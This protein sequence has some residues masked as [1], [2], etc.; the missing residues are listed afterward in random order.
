[1]QPRSANLLRAGVWLAS[2]LALIV[3]AA[4]AQAPQGKPITIRGRIEAVENGA[5]NVT[6]AAGDVLV[7]FADNVRIGAVEAAK[8][9]DVGA[10]NYVAPP[11]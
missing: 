5:L 2:A 11:P 4:Q 8:L 3:G 9:S 6:T 10:G 1:M 7:K